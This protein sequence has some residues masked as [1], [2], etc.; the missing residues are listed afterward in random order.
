MK[1]LSFKKAG[2]EHHPI[3]SWEMRDGT[4]VAIYQGSRGKNPELDYIVKFLSPGKRL[5]APSHTHWIVDLI[6]KGESTKPVVNKYITD[7]VALYDVIEPF[8][9]LEER[10]SYNLTYVEQFE[11]KYSALSMVGEY[12]TE[13]LSTLIELFIKCEKQSSGAYMFKNMLVLVKE[14]CE[15]KKDFY[16][17]ISHSK[18]V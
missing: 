5:R 12:N 18:R 13:F 1:K 7:W 10:S 2:I 6:I 8:R 14:F 9:T 3:N 15:G 17:I 11:K 4:V 16:Q